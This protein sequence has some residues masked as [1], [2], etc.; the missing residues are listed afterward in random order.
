MLTWLNSLFFVPLL[1]FG[2]AS[3]QNDA[4]TLPGRGWWSP[5]KVRQIML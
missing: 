2:I 3:S 4:Q 1:C 5:E